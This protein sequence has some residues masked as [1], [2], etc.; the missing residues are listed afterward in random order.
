MQE[1]HSKQRA[2]KNQSL[3][4]ACLAS[5]RSS[6]EA[7]WLEQCVNHVMRLKVHLGTKVGHPMLEEGFWS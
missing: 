5:S 4:V 3:E 7:V 6:K 2:R 1:E